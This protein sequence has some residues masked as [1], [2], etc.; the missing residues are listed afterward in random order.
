M[1]ATIAGPLD[2]GWIMRF[3]CPYCKAGPGAD[4][5]I[6][7]RNRHFHLSRQRKA[8]GVYNSLTIPAFN[9]TDQ[10]AFNYAASR[11][12][13]DTAALQAARQL[14][15]IVYA[16][17]PEF[18]DGEELRVPTFED[19]RRLITDDAVARAFGDGDPK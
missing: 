17:A 15:A 8:V 9:H 6:R 4:C 14:R 7:Q 5:R 11:R 13:S 16:N 10:L 19:V 18:L 3:T 1:N 2:I 12:R